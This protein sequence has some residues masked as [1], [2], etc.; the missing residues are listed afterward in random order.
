M[1]NG[2]LGE[3]KEGSHEDFLVIGLQTLRNTESLTSFKADG[4]RT[5]VGKEVFREMRG[6]G[7]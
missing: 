5:D 4:G 3:T 2:A 6:R 7:L 1:H